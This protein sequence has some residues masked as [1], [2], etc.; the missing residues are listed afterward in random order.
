VLISKYPGS[1][2]PLTPGVIIYGA[3]CLAM[4]QDLLNLYKI[5]NIKEINRLFNTIAYNIGN[6]VTL[7][8]LS[9]DLLSSKLL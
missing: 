1:I 8:N 5:G 6:E 4:L 2:A 7:E 3:T 9:N